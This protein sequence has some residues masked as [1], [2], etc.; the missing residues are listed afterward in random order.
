M[1]TEN[2][3]DGK[4]EAVLNAV[5][6]DPRYQRN[7][8]W[9]MVRPGHPEGTIA[10]HIRELETLLDNADFDEPKRSKLR[11]L[12]H[13]HD[14]FKGEAARRVPI[15]DPRSHASLS[16]KFLAEFTDDASLVAIVQ[17]HDVPFSLYR[18]S[19]HGAPQSDNLHKLKRD[20]LDFSLFCD[21]LALDA[22]TSGK[23][24]EPQAWFEAS[25]INLSGRSSFQQSHGINSQLR[26]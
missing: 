24:R 2:S 20:V 21:F 5:L 23:G 1:D 25:I 9:G 16:A 18:K 26:H 15:S 7:I 13:V 8:L 4:Y 22:A 11:V 14:T 10:A 17:H 3:E 12:I 19:L 6:R